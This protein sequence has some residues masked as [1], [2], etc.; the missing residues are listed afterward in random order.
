MQRAT[1]HGFDANS[2]PFLLALSLPVSFYLILR[3]KS[4]ISALYRLQM[5]FAVCAILLTGSAI[6]MVAMVIGLSIVAWTFHVVPIRTRAN[7]FA[8][9]VLLG[10]A[11]FML[12]P[13]S[14]WQRISGESGTAQSP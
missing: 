13:A 7:A 10:G 3:E 2:L 4:P 14:L 5:S 12:I 6:T 11:T 1:V 9:I 8:L